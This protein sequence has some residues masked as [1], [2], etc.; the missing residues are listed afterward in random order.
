MP[1]AFTVEFDRLFPRIAHSNSGWF[2]SGT[3]VSISSVSDLE[4]RDVTFSFVGEWDR[5]NVTLNPMLNFPSSSA[6]STASE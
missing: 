4:I 3:L 2:G 6:E 5:S 1:N